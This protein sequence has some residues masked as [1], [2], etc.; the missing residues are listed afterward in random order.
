MALTDL[1]GWGTG[2]G[3]RGQRKEI[4]GKGTGQERTEQDRSGQDKTGTDII[5]A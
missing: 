3:D 1:A 5:G 4:R 2:Q